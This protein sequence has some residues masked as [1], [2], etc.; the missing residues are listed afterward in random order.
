[1]NNAA[2]TETGNNESHMILGTTDEHCDCQ[3]CGRTDLNK[4]VIIQM[5]DGD[6]GWFGTVCASKVLKVE[7]AKIREWAKQA[8]IDAIDA[9]KAF[10]A[11]FEA[12]NS[13]MITRAPALHSAGFAARMAWINS[14]PEHIALQTARQT[15]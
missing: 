14:Q 11:P 13:E 6:V 15:A 10:L 8:D 3:M 4:V 7:A 9:R 5:A 1:M 2:T 12:A